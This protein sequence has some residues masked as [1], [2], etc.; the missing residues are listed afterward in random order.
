MNFIW[1][2]AAAPST[3]TWSPSVAI[4]MILSH[5]VAFGIFSV[6]T[7]PRPAPA[8]GGPALP[9]PLAGLGLPALLAITS[10]GH[11]LGAGSILGL[12]YLGAL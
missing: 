6:T 11:V 10:F 8:P 7:G 1:L 9:G 12:S 3:P 4:V 5:L 2:A